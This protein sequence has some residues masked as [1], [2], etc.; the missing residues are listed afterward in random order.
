MK[1]VSVVGAR[2]NFVKLAPVHKSL[3][4]HCDHVIIHTGQHYDYEMSDV[5]FKELQIPKPHINLGVSSSIPG[6]KLGDMIRGVEAEFGCEKGKVGREG[7]AS[8]PQL[9][10]V[11]GD[12]NSTLAGAIAASLNNIPVAHIEAG[13]RSFDKRMPEERNR[14]LTDHLSD[15]LFAPTNTAV[16]NLQDEH[17]TGRIINSGDVSVE[18][19]AE[20]WK[21]SKSSSILKELSLESKNFIL[22][23]MHRVESVDSYHNLKTVV[24]S[25][26]ELEKRISDDDSLSQANLSNKHNVHPSQFQ[27]VFPIHPRT[28]KMLKSHGLY[29]QVVGLEIVKLIKPLGYIDFLRLVKESSKVVTDSGGLQKEAYLCSVPCITIRKSTEWV[30][31]LN[32]GWNTLC[33]FKKDEIV[34]LILQRPLLKSNYSKDIFGSGNASEIIRDAV[35]FGSYNINNI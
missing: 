2:P 6:K 18:V 30:E 31:T 29:H 17:A 35:I 13:L 28:E 21:F 14:I 10:F 8:K 26:N 5:F 20:A 15:L 19:V 11:Y 22:F 33:A 32:G 4:Q 23:T 3:S 7:I 27:L 25:L 1:I 12:T 16:R 34:N 9:V 24:D